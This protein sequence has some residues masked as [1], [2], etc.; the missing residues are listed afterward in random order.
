MHFY[1]NN[2]KNKIIPAVIVKAILT[3]FATFMINFGE[4]SLLAACDKIQPGILFMILKSEGE[5]I[6]LCVSPERDRKYVICAY[7]NLVCNKSDC[8]L[9]NSL[10]T[11]IGALVELAAKSDRATG[12]F[13]RASA[14][15][16]N[17]EDMLV[18]G[19][20][21]QTFAFQR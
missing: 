4:E 9:E 8:F 19:A 7:T 14:L 20:I 13:A 21:D 2:T 15:E 3:F 16:G 6:K 1:R 18:D 5:K 10:V 17:T 11:V 12:G